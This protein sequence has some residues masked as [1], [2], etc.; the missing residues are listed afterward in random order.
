MKTLRFS[1][2]CL[3]LW[4]SLPAAA[5]PV[6]EGGNGQSINSWKIESI[7]PKDW[8]GELTAT[9]TVTRG[10]ADLYLRRGAAPTE[11]QYDYKAST[12]IGVKS[13]K[14]TNT[15]SPPLT[16]DVWYVGVR[17]GRKTLYTLS[18]SVAAIKSEFAGN[19]ANPFARGTSFRMWAPNASTANIAGQFNNWSATL[20]PMVAEGGGWWSVDYRNANPNQQYKF[21]LK[22]GNNTIWK[23]DPWARSLT[24]SVGNSVI[25]DHSAFTWTNDGF[26]TPNWNDLIIYEV[27]VGTLNDA[28]GGKPGT[29]QTAIQKLDYL[30]GMGINCVELMPVQEFPGDFSWGYNNSH[31]FSVESAYGGPANLKKFIDEANKRGIAVLLDLVH[32]HYGPSDLDLWRFDG[33]YQGQFGGIFFYNDDRAITPW[34]WTRPDFGRGEVRQYIRDNQMEWAE[35]YRVSGFRWDSCLAMRTTNWGD[36]PDGWSLLQWLNDE[37]D[38]SQPW[39][40]NI[41][42]DLQNNSWL[43]RNVSIGGAGF[44]SQW[45]NYVHTVRAA[46]ISPNDGDRNMF[47]IRDAIRESFN[48]DPFERVIYTESHDENA[49]GKQRVPSEI[50]PNDPD[51]YWA[52]KRSTLGAALTF[53]SPGI[54]M[55]FQGQEI[56]EDG[57]FADSDPIDWNKLNTYSGI[58][59]LYKDLIALRRNLAGR[60]NGL[61]GANVNTH[62]VNNTNKVI[63]YHR[64]MNGGSGDDVVVVAN[65]KNATFANYRVGLPRPGGW[66]V[67]FNSD[68]NGYSPLFGNL[69]SPNIT[70][71]TQSY[72]G[73]SH[74]GT[75]NLAPYSVVILTKD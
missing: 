22:N 71:D 7:Q 57:F 6:L 62:H 1:L 25:F 5:Q 73:M 51:S 37:L 32:N 29:F 30:Q 66:S 54:P 45:S 31:P 26:V 64:W 20:S 67:A 43:T 12:G 21:V 19:G 13:L 46:L 75:V 63:A 53:T 40:I 59:L 55:L 58:N 3:V 42:E 74:S 72:D 47:S 9:V 27:H 41:A 38:A 2:A 10:A 61:R 65:F 50:D 15:S 36:N 23:N 69:F 28:P 16:S 52:Q 35:K 60:S 70:A 39:K 24:S 49:N 8:Q 11:S 68:W 17:S 34:G 44:D 56:L 18:K 4:L 14:V 48:G 33:W